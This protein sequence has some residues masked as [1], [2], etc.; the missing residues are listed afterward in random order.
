MRQNLPRPNYNLDDPFN[1]PSPDRTGTPPT[2]QQPY[3]V[4]TVGQSSRLQQQTAQSNRLGT[5]LAGPTLQ[6]RIAM[7][8]RSGLPSEIDWA[9]HELVRMSYQL[10]DDVRIEAV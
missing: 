4:N 9:L 8:L 2:Y 6:H 10:E 1:R 3:Q 5:G 7:A